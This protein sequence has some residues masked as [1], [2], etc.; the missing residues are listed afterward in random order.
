MNQQKEKSPARSLG[1]FLCLL[2]LALA[3]CSGDRDSGSS[4]TSD[5]GS[6]E[7]SW[8]PPTTDTNGAPIELMSIRIY[9]G[10]SAA[11]LQFRTTVDGLETTTVVD[12]LETG[13][14]FFAISAVSI[15]GAESDF[16]NV[17]SK[18]VS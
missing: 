4:V 9:I 13:T 14:H 2:C 3:S 11:D 8:A 15:T 10:T 7:L 1:L 12:K 6:V 5:L 16:S 18:I 17:V